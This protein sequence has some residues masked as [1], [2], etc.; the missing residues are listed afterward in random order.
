[1][2]D[3]D[4]L[5]LG[6]GPAGLGAALRLARAGHR[7]VVL[8]RDAHVGGLTRSFD[9]GG[10]LVDHGS[11]RLHPSTAP[12]IL[13]ELRRLLGDD[14]QLR[15]RHGRIRM[16]GSFVGFP[17][18]PLDLARSLPPRLAGRIARDALVSPLRRVRSDTFAG[19]VRATLGPTL[20]DEFYAPYVRKIWGREPDVLDGELARRRVGAR[21]TRDVVRKAVR[22]GGRGNT[23]W[24]PAHGYGQISEALA[25]AA[26]EAGA[27]IECGAAVNLVELRAGAPRVH[28][29]GRTWDGGAVWST[30]PLPVLAGLA[31]GPGVE[32]EF[33]GLVLVYLV[34]PVARWT[35]YDAHYFPEP[36]VPVSRISEPRNYRDSPADPTDRT[37]LCAEWPCTPGDDVWRADPAALARA[38]RTALAREQ[39]AVPDPL[40]V[41]VRRVPHV[42]PVYDVGF[43]E[44]FAALDAW[45]RT[46]EPALVTF[47]RQGLFAHDNTHHAL[48]MAWAAAA[49]VGG[50]GAFNRV[51]WR[52]AR[53]R[54]ADHVVED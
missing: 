12:E 54:F 52:A 29:A 11:H 41:E 50:D 51:S 36:A 19:V 53:E 21:R 47:G 10:V 38:L 40:H 20:L 32:L 48:A 34:L 8:E 42:Y 45:L 44:R 30:L 3:T 37:V 6:A 22:R 9:V 15:T 2:T 14:L 24:Y 46:V 16:A 13:A 17:P 25:R 1:M 23:F 7:V 5:V 35:E 28:A 39:L 49:C 27:R 4:F 18:R 31:G 33:R 26:R 43:R